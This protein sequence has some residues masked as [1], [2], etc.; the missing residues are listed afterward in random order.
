MDDERCK[1]QKTVH[2]GAAE[3]IVP[4]VLST[5]NNRDQTIPRR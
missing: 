2:S 5:I 3:E 4:V 1:L